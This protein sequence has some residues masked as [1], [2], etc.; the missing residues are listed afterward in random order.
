LFIKNQYFNR[1]APDTFSAIGAQFFYNFYGSFFKF[2]CVFRT[3]THTTAA[4]IAF[5]RQNFY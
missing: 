3:N 4:E 2:D 1:T 5:I